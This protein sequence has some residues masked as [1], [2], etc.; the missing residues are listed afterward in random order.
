MNKQNINDT[1]KKMEKSLADDSGLLIYTFRL[2][3]I[4]KKYKYLI[5]IILIAT[6]IAVVYFIANNAY[7]SSKITKSSNI[8][9]RLEDSKISDLEKQTL[10]KDLLGISPQLYEL[11]TYSKI[12][13]STSLEYNEKSI[14]DLEMLTTSKNDFVSTMSKFNLALIKQDAAFLR[15]FKPSWNDKDLENAA[16]FESSFIYAKNKDYKNA[17]LVLDEIKSDDSRFN[18][19]L[20]VFKKYINGKLN[21]K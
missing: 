8:L 10:E 2:E 7:E 18:I 12:G 15:G 19:N 21:E 11:Y 13:K 17:K 9:T 14:K 5:F 16:K 6:I 20:G 4:Y 3:R 1:F